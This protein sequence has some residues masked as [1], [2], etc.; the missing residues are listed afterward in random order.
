MIVL[1]IIFMEDSDE[2]VVEEAPVA[3]EAAPAE[4]IPAVAEE[5]TSEEV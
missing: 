4:D 5:N 1:H 2:E 3:D